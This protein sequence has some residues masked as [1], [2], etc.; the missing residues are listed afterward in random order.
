MVGQVKTGFRG[1]IAVA[2]AAIASLAFATPAIAAFPGQNGSIAFDRQFRIW[3]KATPDLAAPETMFRDE[4][5]NDS[6]PDFSPDGSLVAFVRNSPGPEIFVASA[7][8]TGTAARLTTNSVVDRHPAWT[9]DGRIVFEQGTGI[10]SMNAD[11][12]G[13]TELTGAKPGDS[14]DYDPAQ[15]SSMP[16]VSPATGRIAF[17][18]QGELWTMAPDG[19]GKGQLA[20]TCAVPTGGVCDPIEANPDFSPDGASIAFEYLGDIYIVPAE[21]GTSVPLAGTGDGRFPSAQLD[22]AWSPDGTMIA[23]E[24][25]PPAQDYDIAWARTSRTDTAPTQIT[26]N[27]ADD[28][29]PN[30]G[31]LRSAG[32]PPVA[33]HERKLTLAYKGGKFKGKIKSSAEPCT[34]TQK[35]KVFEKEKGKDPK[36][37]SDKTSEAGK[38]SVRERG[39]DGRFYAEVKEKTIEGVGVCLAA[40]SKTKKVR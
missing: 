33:E 7:G 21:G 2:A 23:F 34:E 26:D 9:P 10:W 4:G 31:V 1:L 8:G 17:I 15:P 37:A 3:L 40:T 36:V 39:A 38:F 25:A 22:P 5:A 27:A 30:W 29:N 28:L 14:A 35:V 16:A 6:Q 20:N 32:P 11:G 18:H 12:S 13:Q 24:S 19:S